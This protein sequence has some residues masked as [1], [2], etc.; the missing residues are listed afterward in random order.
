MSAAAPP[1][2]DHAMNQ[3]GAWTKRAGVVEPFGTIRNGKKTTFQVSKK[4]EL[5]APDDS[6]CGLRGVEQIR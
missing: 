1:S 4:S 6:S 2:T 3:T 5:I